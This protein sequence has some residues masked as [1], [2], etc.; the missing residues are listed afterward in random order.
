MIWAKRQF[1]VKVQENSAFRHGLIQAHTL[2]LGDSL[3]LPLRL[4]A[5]LI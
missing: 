4:S 2:L 5:F 3:L 1:I